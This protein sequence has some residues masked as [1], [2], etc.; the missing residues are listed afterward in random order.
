[1]TTS[2]STASFEARQL[3]QFETAAI[4]RTV[5]LNLKD[6]NDIDR[7]I[8]QVGRH[9]FDMCDRCLMQFTQSD[10]C[11]ADNVIRYWALIRL[12]FE[13]EMLRIDK[14]GMLKAAN[15]TL[16]QFQTYPLAESIKCQ[17]FSTLT[18]RGT[19]VYDLMHHNMWFLALSN[20]I[21]FEECINITMS[22]PLKLSLI[23]HYQIDRI[24]DMAQPIKSWTKWYFSTKCIDQFTDID[25]TSETFQQV[26]NTIS[27][28]LSQ[29]EDDDAQTIKYLLL[30]KSSSNHAIDSDSVNNI[31]NIQSTI[32]RLKSQISIMTDDQDAVLNAIRMEW[33]LLNCDAIID[34]LPQFTAAHEQQ[35]DCI[36]TRKRLHP[37]TIVYLEQRFTEPS[38]IPSKELIALHGELL[39]HYDSA[40]TEA[41][42]RTWLLNRKHKRKRYQMHGCESDLTVIPRYF[43]PSIF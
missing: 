38:V 36:A 31:V 43:T 11:V 6:L 1:M 15:I 27:R 22:S 19:L 13:R 10:P 33:G 20:K 30:Y 12:E 25:C 34:S 21:K 14:T 26:Q 28:N 7:Y 4:N 16:E 18:K 17:W 3:R 23:N 2:S 39:Y 9:A 37:K 24:S 40:A 35:N 5:S 32:D 29:L 8:Y 41:R 42:I